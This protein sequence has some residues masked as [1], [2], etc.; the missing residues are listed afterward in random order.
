MKKIRLDFDSEK[1]NRNQSTNRYLSIPS[2]N[3]KD[4]KDFSFHGAKT[5]SP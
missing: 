4:S 5:K 3:S 1:E 2:S